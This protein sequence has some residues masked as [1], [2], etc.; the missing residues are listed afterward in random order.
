M[1]LVERM[2]VRAILIVQAYIDQLM[3]ALQPLLEQEFGRR[4]DAA[5]RA[6]LAE[7]F[8]RVREGR[9]TFAF[10]EQMFR[11]VDHQAA[12]DLRRVVPVTT[13]DILP[14]ARELEQKW[15]E[16]NT[17]LIRLEA[18]AQ[19]EVAHIFENNG[20][21]TRVEVVREQI[22]E[23]LGV[24]RS[25]AELIARDQTLKIY[26]EI[27]EERQ[28]NAGITHYVWSTSEDERVRP[29]HED[30]DGTT[31]AWDDPP[32]VDKRT[33]QRGHP[34]S[35]SINCRCAAVPVLDD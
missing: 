6:T 11:M 29:D 21:S 28:R 25:R 35:G 1:D 31:Q 12:D 5:D 2:Q 9:F 8:R 22:Q 30:L 19:D 14:N 3:R 18:R 20:A 15:I 13:R 24:V 23:R 17:D 16:R 33:G 7:V 32:V 10:L 27:Q 4:Q 34:G 26:G